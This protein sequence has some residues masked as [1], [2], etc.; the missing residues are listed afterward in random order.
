MVSD[1]LKNASERVRCD[2]QNGFSR[3]HSG[4]RC[5]DSHLIGGDG[6]SGGDGGGFSAQTEIKRQGFQGNVAGSGEGGLASHGQRSA[7]LDVVDQLQSGPLVQ[8]DS[9]VVLEGVPGEGGGVIG[10]IVRVCIIPAGEEDFPL[11]SPPG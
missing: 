6:T 9:A 4:R 7:F 2:G 5:I 3:G 1:F 8:A 11:A 10:G